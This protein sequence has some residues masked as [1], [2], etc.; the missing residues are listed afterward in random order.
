MARLLVD[1]RTRR[2]VSVGL[3]LLVVATVVLVWV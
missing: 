2:A 3:A 1:D